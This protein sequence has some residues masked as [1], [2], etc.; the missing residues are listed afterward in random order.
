MLKDIPTKALSTELFKVKDELKRFALYEDY[1]SLYNKTVPIV[2]ANFEK[3]Q[4][5]AVELL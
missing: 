5:M 2:S 1:T 3:V 4:K